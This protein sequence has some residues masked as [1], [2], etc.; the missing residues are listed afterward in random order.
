MRMQ[1]W[2][3]ALSGRPPGSSSQNRYPQRTHLPIAPLVQV[4]SKPPASFGT[5]KPKIAEAAHAARGEPSPFAPPAAD[6]LDLTKPLDVTA[7]LAER[8]E[9]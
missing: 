9:E 3:S 1:A 2:C 6:P 8:R 4:S 5:G 7:L